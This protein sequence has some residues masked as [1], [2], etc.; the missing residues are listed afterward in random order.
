LAATSLPP[1]ESFK[2]LRTARFAEVLRGVSFTPGTFVSDRDDDERHADNDHFGD[3]RE[4][5]Q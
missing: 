3:H 2:T 1:G 5:M 4:N